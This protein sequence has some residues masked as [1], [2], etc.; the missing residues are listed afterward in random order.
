M[1]LQKNTKEHISCLGNIFNLS[2]VLNGAVG[3]LIPLGPGEA[4]I[5]VSLPTPL[6]ISFNPLMVNLSGSSACAFP[7]VLILLDVGF[8]PLP[9]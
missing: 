6:L 1:E 3:V 5:T 8:V 7:L 4:V 9:Y 2:S